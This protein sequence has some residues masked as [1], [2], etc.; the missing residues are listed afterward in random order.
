[1]TVVGIAKLVTQS[2]NPSVSGAQIRPISG[3]L[4]FNLRL[5][6]LSPENIRVRVVPGAPY[7]CRLHTNAQFFLGSAI[8]INLF[9][10][11]VLQSLSLEMSKKLAADCVHLD[12]WFS[13]GK[14]F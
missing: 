3:F 11:G 1:M 5:Y 7:P 9:W 12:Q 6:F 4:E 14:Y 2:A 10:R 13:R 8:G